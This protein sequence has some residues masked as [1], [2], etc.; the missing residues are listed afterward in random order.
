MGRE[1]RKLENETDYLE[2]GGDGDSGE[3]VAELLSEVVDR[4]AK[5][6][7]YLCFIPNHVKKWLYEADL[8]QDVDFGKKDDE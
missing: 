5:D 4:K 1:A 2:M 7:F 8:S 6:G 3:V